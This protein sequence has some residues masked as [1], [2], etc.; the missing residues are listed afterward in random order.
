MSRV[1]VT[2][3]EGDEAFFKELLKAH[4]L[5]DF[6]VFKRNNRNAGSGAFRT[7]L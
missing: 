6:T 3:G 2:E 7:M 4:R 5:I 1:I